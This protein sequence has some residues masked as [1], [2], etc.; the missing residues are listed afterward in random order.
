MPKI[1]IHCHLGRDVDGK[2]QSVSEILEHMAEF[3]V[4]YSVIFPLDTQ[5]NDGFKTDNKKIADASK[6][7]PS[8]IGFARLDP[9]HPNVLDEMDRAKEHGLKGFKLHPKAQKFH[10]D[11]IPRIYE[12]GT[13]LQLPFMIHSAH[14][15]G[16]YQKELQNIV[17]S[18]PDLTMILA[19]A[20]LGDQKPIVDLVQNHENAFVDISANHKHDIQLVLLSAG[21]DKVLFGSDAPYQSVKQTIERMQIDWSDDTSIEKVMYG[22]AARILGLKL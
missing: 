17:P 22:N 7:K 5:P 21:P 15:Q 4:K 10:L 18:F 2:Y 6:K 3:N 20:G 12:K 14:K 1:D 9:H 11:Q 13:D 16:I 8:L 19:H